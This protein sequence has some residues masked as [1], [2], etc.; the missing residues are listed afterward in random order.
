VRSDGGCHDRDLRAVFCAKGTFTAAING[1]GPTR[2]FTSKIARRANRQTPVQP[3]FEK[4]SASA[5]AKITSITWPSR[6]P[7]G[8]SRSSRTR[9]GMRWTRAASARKWIR[10]A[11]SYRT[12][13]RHPARRRTAQ[14]RTAKSCGPD[15]PTLAS[16]WRRCIEP[17]RVSIAPYPLSDG[18]KQAR[19]PGRARNKPLKPLCR[20]CRVSR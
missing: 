1:R 13:E 2:R 17:D 7:E 10:R 5:F 11:S 16:S 3:R 8:R 4:Y 9:N 20:K 15:A 12:C 6:S 19:S 18:G 14:S